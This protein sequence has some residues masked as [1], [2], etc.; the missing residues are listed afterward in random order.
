[1]T[2]SAAPDKRLF[3]PF[4]IIASIIILGAIPLVFMR[5]VGGLSAVGEA[6]YTQPWG[7]FIG[8]NVTFFVQFIAGSQGMPRRYADYAEQ[9]QI[10]HVISSLGSYLL[11]VGLVM[12]AAVWIHGLVRGRPAP[13]NPWGGNTLEWHCTSPPPHENFARTP[14]ADDPYEVENWAYDESIEGYYKTEAQER[15]SARDE[16]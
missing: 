7:V 3:T 9:F 6:S 13:A 15:N 2:E 16:A 8:F 5:F 14:T 1:M 4:N 11:A 12:V 10:Y